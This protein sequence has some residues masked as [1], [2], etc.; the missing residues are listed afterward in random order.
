MSHGT[1]MGVGPG[2]GLGLDVGG[3]ASR[4]TLAGADGAPLA[5]GALPGFS[6]GQVHSA[7]GLAQVQ[8]VLAA[9]AA[10]LQPWPRP[11]RLCAGITGHDAESGDA[12][13]QL[14]ARHLGLRPAQVELA[15][16]V[17][18]QYFSSFPDHQGLLLLAG[19]GAIAGLV[20]DQGQWQRAGGRGVLVDDAGGGHW[21]ATRALRGVWR[22]EDAAPG[23]SASMPLARRLAAHIGGSA[24]ADVRHW[25]QAASRG[26]VGRL[27]LAV[28]L[29]A[30]RDGD[31]AAQALL[32]RAGQQLA[33]PVLALFGRHGPRPVALA[34]RAWDL[35]PWLQQ[36]LQ[37]RL[38]PGQ[39]V[40]RLTQP[41][42]IA[43][44]LR[45]TRPWPA[46]HGP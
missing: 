46:G 3:S 30:T 20:D 9:L 35:G 42:E 43:A 31:A 40:H 2:V 10:A 6:G 16:D 32:L 44:A 1:A 45:A 14:L 41:A 39:P 33:R 26:D 23:A 28:G 5:Q 21:I 12:L 11:Q 7:D 29:A 37:Q 13:R 36:G 24:W 15:S 8:Q 19:T 4:W 38:P 34:G 27:A 17:Q 18:M 25:L 22:A